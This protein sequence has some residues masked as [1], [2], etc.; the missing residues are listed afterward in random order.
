MGGTA[1]S[2][3]YNGSAIL[4]T[5]RMPPEIYAYL[6]QEYCKRLKE[7][8]EHVDCPQEAPGKLD[9]GDIDVVVSS[10]LSSV[11][12]YAGLAT[13]LPVP[14]ASVQEYW[15]DK[16][17]E[18]NYAV[19]WP[20]FRGFYYSTKQALRHLFQGSVRQAWHNILLAFERPWAQVDVTIS[21]PEHFAWK[22]F[23][24]SHGDALP[25]FG[26]GTKGSGLTQ[27]PS[28]LLLR[29]EE[30]ERRAQNGCRILLSTSPE[31]VMDFLGLDRG[32]YAQGFAR[33]DE[34]FA[35]VASSRFFDRSMFASA[36]TP[37]KRK[38]RGMFLRFVDEWLPAN[39]SAGGAGMMTRS[40]IC[41]AALDHFDKRA[42]FNARL[43]FWQCKFRE[44]D[45]WTA[46]DA[47]LRQPRPV[48]H[49]SDA[50]RNE[51]I[52]A[53]KRFVKFQGTS[54]VVRQAAEMNESQQ[55]RWSDVI[56]QNDGAAMQKMLQWVDAN[57]ETIRLKER[58]RVRGRGA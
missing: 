47:F 22:V 23:Q 36:E 46:I 42:E 41:E 16:H 48:E 43:S 30:I 58:D 54:P 15:Q 8:F 35:W 33:E 4:H 25:I 26:A 6:K 2:A 27:G 44:D 17:Q 9:Y 52:R 37:R 34:I 53:L 3:G 24:K 11:A 12:D 38:R 19:R 29:I 57:R 32:R 1:F 28:G 51:T 56:D 50:R 13:V 14:N 55:S 18:A 20:L 7:C 21:E 49:L 40:E 45:L 10:P 31:D 5:P 39:P